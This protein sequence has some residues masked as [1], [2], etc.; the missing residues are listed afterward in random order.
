MLISVTS[1]VLLY[2]FGFSNYVVIV[3]AVVV[4]LIVCRS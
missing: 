4:L 1:V 2:R 3:V